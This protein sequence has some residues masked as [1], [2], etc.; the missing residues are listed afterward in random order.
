MAEE[1]QSDKVVDFSYWREIKHD[2]ER[3]WPLMDDGG[4]G[5]GGEPPGPP[6][7]E[8]KGPPFGSDHHVALVLSER[9]GEDWV[10]GHPSGTWYQWDGRRWDV[11]RG[12]GVNAV[13]RQV[14]ADVS[15]LIESKRLQRDIA[16]EGKAR[17]ALT[18]ASHDPRQHRWDFEFDQD[19]DWQLNTPAGI[20][21]LKNGF[22]MPHARGRL[23]TRL[24]GAAPS[25]DAECP[26][27]MQFLE[28]ATGG[29]K[30]LQAYLQRLAGYCLTGSVEEHAI[31]F[32]FS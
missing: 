2:D 27:W 17:A 20:L 29:D 1:Q 16:R 21:Q 18:F 12:S 15:V 7:D 22:V 25:P 19:D 10:C 32:L 11:S 24:A 30:E 31:F 23:L 13:A 8:Q 3:L 26:R 6:A 5:G 9:L 28:E 14:C 4:G